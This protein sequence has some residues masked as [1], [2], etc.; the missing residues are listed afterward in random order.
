MKARLKTA[1][2]MGKVHIVYPQATNI[3][4]IGK[5]VQ[6]QGKV[7]LVML[8]DL[9]TRVILQMVSPAE[10]VKLFIQMGELTVANGLREGFMAKVQHP[11]LTA[12]AMR[13]TSGPPC[14]ME[15]AS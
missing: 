4:V 11:I 6:S 1:A 7:L 8:M 5:M 9:F 14:V 12:C 3:Q 2:N 13:V 15:K 10:T